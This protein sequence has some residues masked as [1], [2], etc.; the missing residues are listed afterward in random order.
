MRLLCQK[1]NRLHK[2]GGG[3][4]IVNLFIVI[5]TASREK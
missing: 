4:A 1:K 2:W 3:L 5:V